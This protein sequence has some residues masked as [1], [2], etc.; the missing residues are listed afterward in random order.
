MKNTK[1]FSSEK[2]SI[3]R[4]RFKEYH[5]KK[6]KNEQAQ[7]NQVPI[8]IENSQED[9]AQRENLNETEEKAKASENVATTVKKGSLNGILDLIF[10][11]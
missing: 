2:V 11:I 8:I 3:A 9:G 7:T 4:S 10:Y 6:F 5:R 1:S